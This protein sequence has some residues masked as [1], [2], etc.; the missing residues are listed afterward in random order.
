M[1]IVALHSASTGLSA[2]ST[3][4]DVISNNLANVNTTGFK[5]LRSNFQDLIYQEKE[6][7]GVENANGDQR[8]A[9]LFV[10]LGTKIANTQASFEQGPTVPTGQD[11][12]LMI[13]GNGFF[14]VD[15]LDSQGD[16][17][18]TR[19]GNFFTN[20][21]GEIVLGN[22]DGPRLEPP[23]T[24]PE[25]A[26]TINISADGTVS[27]LL[28]GET[29]LTEIGQIQL[30]SF[31]NPSGLR[32]IGG[33]LWVESAASGPPVEGNP[34]EGSLGTILQNHLEGSNVN[35]V[36][37]LISL[38][39]TQRAFEMNSQTIQAA[40]EVLQVVSNLRR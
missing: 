35:P 30:A 16:V 25:D 9:G 12:D 4:I 8:P 13:Q 36:E 24:I 11:L 28:G 6:Q 1:A 15:I 2:M 34:G 27:V 18:Y 5:T 26:T 21:D 20:R 40:D 33:N 38:I 23:I 29:E 17:G 22:S 7:P 19:S 32:Q 14:Q 39:K 3:A 10:G 31:V 37:E